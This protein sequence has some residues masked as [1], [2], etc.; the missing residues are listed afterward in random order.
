MTTGAAKKSRT[1]I[2]SIKLLQR[3]YKAKRQ[4]NKSRTKEAVNQVAQMLKSNKAA[5]AKGGG[6]FHTHKRKGKGEGDTAKR[7]RASREANE[8]MR[9]QGA[10]RG[11]NI[12]DMLG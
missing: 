6:D 11:I 4:S 12:S 7:A 5:P 2:N 8:Y 9:I 3:T 10:Q 1:G